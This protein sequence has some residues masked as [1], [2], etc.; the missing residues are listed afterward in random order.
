[1]QA[2]RVETFTPIGAGDELSADYAVSETLEGATCRA[3]SQAVVN[4][5]R[6]SR[7]SELYDPCWAEASG[8]LVCVFD[9]WSTT[10]VRLVPNG[11][12][13]P[14]P[15]PTENSVPWAIETTE[16]Q[17]CIV[18]Q[19]A[20]ESVRVTEAVVDYYC[21]D[22]VGLVRGIDRTEPVWRMAQARLVGHRY[23]PVPEQA[24]IAVAW[25]G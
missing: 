3:E 8:A 1:M 2:T 24:L 10:A 9:P 23:E 7:G 20:H 4:G 13:E 25:F 12:L 11:E 19:G 21:P 16:G 5:Y 6:C 14:L 15:P 17:R 18:A 22:G